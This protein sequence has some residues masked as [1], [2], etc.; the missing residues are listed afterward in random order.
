MKDEKFESAIIP[1]LHHEGLL[2][3]NPQDPGGI[4]N[5]GISLRFLRAEGID[6]DGD[7]DSDEHDVRGLTPDKAKAIYKEFFWDRYKFYKLMH[8]LVYEK[9]FDLSVNMGGKAAIKLLQQS[10]NSMQKYHTLEEDGI[11]GPKTIESTNRFNPNSVRTALR[12][13]AKQKYLRIL[14]ANPELEY[15]RAGWLNRARW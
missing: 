5:F 1:V 3:D 9:V 10:I 4:T 13:N 15:A 14:N 12:L 8:A 6:V 11:L 2:S 7:G